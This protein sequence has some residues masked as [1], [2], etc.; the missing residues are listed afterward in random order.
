VSAALAAAALY[1]APPLAG[2]AIARRLPPTAPLKLRRSDLLVPAGLL[3]QFEPVL[4]TL[5]LDVAYVL[6]GMWVVTR[7]LDA[8]SPVERA[9]LVLV[10]SG[11]LMNGAAILMNGRMPFAAHGTTD[12]GLK[13]VAIDAHTHL[14]AL[15]DTIPFLGKLVSPGDLLLAAGTAL[16]VAAVLARLS[17]AAPTV[18]AR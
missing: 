12:G 10:A 3:V 8:A 15:G 6:L 18:E 4:H 9:A 13:G 7:L 2:V 1:G 16:L 17:A 11:G 5:A 14:A